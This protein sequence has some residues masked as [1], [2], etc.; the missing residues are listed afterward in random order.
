MKKLVL[1]ASLFFIWGSTS[2]SQCVSDTILIIETVCNGECVE[3]NNTNFCEDGFY[4]VE[5]H[6]GCD[7]T[8]YIMDLTVLPPLET[9][10]SELIC[11]GEC[12][13]YNGEELCETGTYDFYFTT[14]LGCD[15]TVTINLEVL[16]NTQLEIVIGNTGP[17]DCVNNPIHLLASSSVPNSTY[18][19]EGPGIDSN[20]QN[21]QAP[22]VSLPGIYT[23]TVT[24]PHGCSATESTVVLGDPD[25]PEVTITGNNPL[26]CNNL[27]N[28]IIASTNHP[29]DVAY[30]WNGPGGF[31]SDSNEIE[32]SETGNYILTVETEN[33]CITQVV[34]EVIENNEPL[35]VDAGPNRHI[36]CEI[37]IE[38]DAPGA[39][40]SNLIYQWTTT[41]GNIIS[42]SHTLTPLVNQSG[43]YT[44]TVF[45]LDTGCMGSDEMIVY[46]DMAIITEDVLTMDCNNPILQ[47]DGSES[48]NGQD[49]YIQ[50]TTT[51]GNIVT[52]ENSLTPTVDAPGVYQLVIV[53]PGCVSFAVAIVL[54]DTEAPDL[55]IDSDGTLVTC[56]SDLVLTAV[57][58][59]SDLTYMWYLDGNLIAEQEAII[60][61]EEGEYE[62]IVT[63]PN[64]CSN[65]ESISIT[66]DIEPEASIIYGDLELDCNL[67]GVGTLNVF[68]SGP[69]NLYS[70]NWTTT[71]GTILSNNNT[72]SIS[73]LG[74]G[75]YCV[76]IS[77]PLNGCIV[78]ECEEVTAISPIDLDI[79]SMDASCANSNDGFIEVEGIGGTLPYSYEWS[80]GETSSSIYN[81]S[82]G[83]YTVTV[84]DAN[85]C[86]DYG[87]IEIGVSSNSTIIADAGQDQFF[88]C[89]T[90]VL[91][92][93]GSNSEYPIDATFEWS[94]S[95]GEIV[96]G[97]NTLF[98]TIGMHGTYL[99]TITD[100]FGCSDTDE[101]MVFETTANAGPNQSI[102]CNNS[103]VQLDGSQ[104]QNSGTYI[105][106]TNDGNIVD[107]ETTLNPT[108]NEIGTY[109][110]TVT[111]PNGCTA[112]SS[113]EVIGDFSEPDL[114]A[115]NQSQES[116]VNPVQLSASSNDPGTTFEWFDEQGQSLGMDA[117][118]LE[119]GDYTVVATGTNGCTSETTI[120]VSDDRIYPEANY[121]SVQ[122]LNCFNGIPFLLDFEIVNS[123]NV[124]TEWSTANGNIVEI[125]GS[126][127]L[128]DQ[129]GDYN[130]IMTEINGGCESNASIEVID[131][132]VVINTSSTNTSCG[133]NDG[134]ASVTTS[135]INLPVF[136]W[137]NGG[138]TSTITD[139]APGIYT[140]TIS[141]PSGNCEEIRTVEVLQ[142]PGCL[143]VIS[144]FVYND[145]ATLGCDPD[146][147]VFG[148][149][150]VTVQLLPD[151]LYTTT[152]D[153]GYYEFLVPAGSYTVKA[154]TV[155][156]YVVICPDD[157]EINVDINPGDSESSDNNFF[158]DVL[159]NFDL[160]GYGSS[161]NPQPG[162]VQHYQLTYC[163]N[164]FQ[165][166]DG[167]VVFTHD[168][169]LT[170][171]D[172]NASG[173]TSY[174]P[175]TFT[176][177][178]DFEQLSFFECEYITFTLFV[179]GDVQGGTVLESEMIVLPTLGDINSSN[180]NYSWTR[181]VHDPSP[182]S[183]G[184]DDNQSENDQSMLTG[185]SPKLFQNHPNPFSN[186]TIIP[187][188]IVDN[189][190]LN[191]LDMNGRLIKQFT[192][193]T[194]GY[195]EVKVTSEDL[196]GDGIY[197]FQLVTKNAT[198]TEKMV[199]I[200]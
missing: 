158:L 6:D 148:Q 179:P 48:Y 106:T 112:T 73:I 155:S 191:V 30:E 17:L 40:G 189:G 32:V 140:V 57:S 161:S 5:V 4:I 195:H 66:T 135:R 14:S 71:D 72:P 21:E 174:D 51:N 125:Q 29:D 129:G 185:A 44:L 101:V 79:N 115:N 197:Y 159:S 78:T 141:S 7:T 82:P 27:S 168:P 54:D 41:D 34:V 1:L 49:A 92:L 124:D 56:D 84:T 64:G 178:W 36:Q 59:T 93:N 182:N 166:I 181:T 154:L 163:N 23:V 121:P 138:T 55:E 47:I 119:P 122:Y 87:F 172:L 177:T 3:I 16:E 26:N 133:M 198:I 15:S 186:T 145:D 144:G 123:N 97:A 20:N 111:S 175:A 90:N 103:S 146:G 184:D 152:D 22:E 85:N 126:S 139:L 192:G 9:N 45:D 180:N 171:F 42:G 102:D 38:L 76:D 167:T 24:S 164:G 63:A 74:A 10:L 196:G 157:E 188:Y 137:S 104:S 170:G 110:L 183:I 60:A 153:D 65:S 8:T 169:V 127:I 176:A 193:F 132:G 43:T 173:A 134:T 98:P 12:L 28:T 150:E 39:D 81:L 80:N 116:C 100:Q 142:D 187:I 62:V 143:A 162:Q 95:D 130:V 120:T 89:L 147:D 105:W 107:G 61:T 149:E 108:V 37:L 199:F 69:F 13:N 68:A 165:T 109:T 117:E 67:N 50:W 190:K 75:T 113:T 53:R 118:A 70:F 86:F 96:D 58:N 18:F 99:L 160:Y 52:G 91:V 114:T 128:V 131:G 88:D 94:T 11:E 19:W 136:E 33:G 2:Y 31:F 83:T 46:S 200:R 151:D 35:F 25:G 194:K 77:N 156:P